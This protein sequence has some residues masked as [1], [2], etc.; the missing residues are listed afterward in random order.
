ME[1]ML[2]PEYRSFAPPKSGLRGKRL[3][4]GNGIEIHLAERLISGRNYISS[5]E[6]PTF[7]LLDE[8]S[9]RRSNFKGEYS[10]L[11][12]MISSHSTGRQLYKDMLHKFFDFEISIPN[13]NKLIEYDLVTTDLTKVIDENIWL[14][15]VSL[16][17][18]TPSISITLQEEQRFFELIKE[19]IETILIERLP[20]HYATIF[21]EMQAEKCVE[22]LKREAKSLARAKDKENVDFSLLR[23][24]RNNFLDRF[25]DLENDVSLGGIGFD[26][27]IERK[28]IRNFIVETILRELGKATVEEI[29]QR[30]NANEDFKT[31][32]NSVDALN[33]LLKRAEQK[34]SV[35]KDS[36]RRYILLR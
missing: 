35:I 1:L 12:A 15:V 26:R 18:K 19:D 20:E 13:L 34:N 9:K 4:I 27:I 10:I 29:Y 6:G 8:E 2:P 36:K 21:S 23:N 11:G 3:D 32:F 33:R 31:F 30:V 28:Q 22:N 14:Q 7:K 25:W 16:R 5:I 24:A 17:H